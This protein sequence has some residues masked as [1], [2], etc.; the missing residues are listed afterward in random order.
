MNDKLPYMFVLCGHPGSGKTTFAKEFAKQNGFRYLSI[1]DT[2]A[3]FNGNP[4]SHDNKFDVWLTFWR[5]IHAA[6]L[7]KCSVVIDVN[8]PTKCDRDD[9]LNWFPSFEHHLIEVWALKETCRENNRHR[10][11][12]IPEAQFD[13]ILEMFEPIERSEIMSRRKV[14]SNWKSY[15]VI[16]NVNNKFTLYDMEFG[17][18]LPENIKINILEN[19]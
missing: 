17:T 6:E 14:R 13:E 11:R 8:A 4:T 2:Y 3:V 1:D 15:A 7:Q 12:V 18:K 10:E 19:K 5:Q 9:F 16:Y